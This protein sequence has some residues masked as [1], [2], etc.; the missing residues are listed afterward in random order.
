MRNLIIA[1]NIMLVVLIAACDNRSVAVEPEGVTPPATSAGIEESPVPP[2]AKPDEPNE[3]NAD[4]QC[5]V[6]IRVDD[7]CTRPQAASRTEIEADACLLEVIGDRPVGIPDACA[8]KW[9]AICATVRCTFSPAPSSLATFDGQ[10]CVFADECQSDADCTM[11]ADYAQC[12]SCDE[13]QPIALVEN[14]PCLASSEFPSIEGCKSA[15]VGD[16]GS[17]NCKADNDKAI[18]QINSDKGGEG[19]NICTPA[20]VA[21]ACETLGVCDCLAR[22]ECQALGEQCFCPYEHSCP[23]VGSGFCYCGGGKFLGC[24]AK[25]H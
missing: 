13:A 21:P 24:A 16:C 17:Y 5:A 6:A 19:K 15:C 1:G 20:P 22:P 14:A 18:C 2:P 3:P 11:A 9:P 10:K 8:A 4:P 25:E 7:C 23:A 12:C